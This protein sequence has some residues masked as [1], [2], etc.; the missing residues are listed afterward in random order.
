VQIKLRWALPL[1]REWAA[2]GITSLWEISHEQVEAALPESGNDRFTVA[3]GLHAIFKVLK[4]HKVVFVDFTAR[5]RLGSPERQIPLPTNITILREGSRSPDPTRAVMTALPAFHGLR[6]GQL[7]ALLLTDIHDGRLHLDGDT[8]GI[9][10]VQPVRVRRASHLDY[11][12]TRWP[13]TANP[14]LFIHYRTALGTAPVGNRWPGLILSLPARDLRTDR[15]LDEVHAT[16]GDVRRI[17]DLFGLSVKAALRYT[18]VL[19]HPDL[20]DPGR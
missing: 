4:A 1:L 20:T 7:R 15:I 14:H 16:G 17:C 13:G 6:P 19:D 11:R 2:E 9:P 8:R 12:N 3:S 18:A 5:V 10:L